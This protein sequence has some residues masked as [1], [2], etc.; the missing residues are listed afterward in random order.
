MFLRKIQIMTI[1]FSLILP[2]YP[3]QKSI[4]WRYYKVKTGDS[5]FKLFRNHWQ[6]V[7]RFNRIDEKHL[8]IGMK[9]KVPWDLESIEDYEPLPLFLEDKKN[10]L[11]FIL[12]DRAEQWLG[13]YQKGELI[14]SVPISSGIKKCLDEKTQEIKKCLTPKGTF[15]TLAFHHDHV[16]SIYKDAENNNIP[17]PFAI[18]FFIDKKGV[19]YWIHAGDLPGRPASHG[20][21]RLEANN[22]EKLYEFMNLDPN[23]SE[24]KWL[25]KN[26][27][28][29]IEIK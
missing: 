5:F 2:I 7:A 13:A 15:S 9:I 12:V 23:N 11:K 18:M 26:K 16:S 20:C 27:R 10:L 19:A 1:A 29:T 24:I 14:F 3:S 4:D 6:S 17:M 28:I 25:P 22:A 21:V 8:V